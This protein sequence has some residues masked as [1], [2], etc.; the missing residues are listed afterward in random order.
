MLLKIRNAVLIYVSGLDF[1]RDITQFSHLQNRG[2]ELLYSASRKL[3]KVLRFPF[4]LIV[5]CDRAEIIGIKK[6]PSE[7]LERALSLNPAA[8]TKC[9]YHIEGEEAEL[10]LF[11]L[12]SGII[13]PLFG[14]DTVQGQ[15]TLAAEAAR[16]AGSSCPSLNKLCNAAVAFGK[17]MHSNYRI[18]VFDKSIAEAVAARVS[19][20]RN[21]LITGS[22]ENA[23]IV[24]SRLLEDGHII[25]IALRDES[26]TFLILPGTSAVSYD[27]RMKEAEWADAVISASSGLYYTFTEAECERI[28]PKRM[29]DLAFPYDLPLCPNVVRISDLG[30]EEKEKENVISLVKAEA[31]KAHAEYIS[32]QERS[33]ERDALEE[34]AEEVAIESI[35]RLSS[36]IVSLGLS[37]DEEKN[38]RLSV[39]DS[40]KKAYITKHYER[41]CM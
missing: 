15:L 24:A 11:H 6:V 14:E 33:E 12:A 30:V 9:R 20:D 36:H 3:M 31:L 5:T 10:H 34:R 21:I 1:T 2:E 25:H 8:V 29:Y 38:L 18:R 37:P 35:R 13:S 32:W 22:G 28:A 23:R 39:I 27:D 17:E 16:L 26:K 7:S 41:S 19:N 4:V 40:V